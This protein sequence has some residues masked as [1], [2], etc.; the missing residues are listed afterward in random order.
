MRIGGRIFEKPTSPEHWVK[1]HRDAGYRAAYC[2][3]NPADADAEIAAYAA[4]AVEHDLPIAETGAWSNPISPDPDQRAKAIDKCV[5][6]LS[7]AERLGARC[8]VNIAGSMDPHDWHG[9][10]AGNYTPDCF[11][12]IVRTVQN[13]I[14]QVRPTRTFYT[15]EMMSW[16]PPDSAASYLELIAAIDR[17]AF[18]VHF[19]PVNLINTPRRFYDNASVMS[20]VIDTLGHRIKSVHIKDVTLHQKQ[21]VHLDEC[22]PGTGG[23]DYVALFRGLSK[24]DPDLP[25]MLEHLPDATQYQLAADHLRAVAAQHGFTL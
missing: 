3:V 22:R 5:A 4:A 21:L 25:V 10:H 6:M 24:L 20:E 8:C 19:D 2:P 15:L 16:C 11:D 17:D 7:L 18:A 14:D 13:I 1:L 9:H 12:R 23:L